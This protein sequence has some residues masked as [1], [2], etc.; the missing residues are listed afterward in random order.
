M[1]I[2]DSYHFSRLIYN[3]EDRTGER[4]YHNLAPAQWI[5][6]KAVGVVLLNHFKNRLRVARGNA[7][8]GKIYSSVP[9]DYENMPFFAIYHPDEKNQPIEFHWWTNKDN[10]L[11]LQLDQF[12]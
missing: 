8:I 3:W 7:E 12:Q 4:R 9:F 11:D 6:N 5:I 10:D 2:Q 1:L